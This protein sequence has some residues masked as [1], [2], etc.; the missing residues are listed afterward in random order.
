[1]DLDMLSKMKVDELK[2]FLRLRGLKVSGRKEELVARAF[3]AIE[4]NV[5]IVQTAE[6]VEAVIRKQYLAKLTVALSDKDTEEIPDPFKLS[7]G[8]I[9]EEEGVKLW[10]PTLYPDIFNFLAFHPSELAS[11]DLSDYKTSKGYSYYERG[12]LK[13]LS[14]NEISSASQLCLLKTT[15]RP[16]QRISDVPHKL[17]VC[18]VKKTGKIMSA[19]CSCMAG[20]GQ[21]CNHVAAALF[22]IEAAVRMGLSNPSCTSTTCEWLPN[23]TQV[24]PMKIKDLKLAHGNF[25]RRGKK[26]KELNS[27]PKKM[28]NPTMNFD[29]SLTLTDIC[30]ALKSVCKADESI[31]FAA[32]FKDKPLCEAEAGSNVSI[33]TFEKVLLEASIPEEFFSKMDYFAQHVNEIEEATRGQSDNSFWFMLRKHVITASKVHDVK[34]RMSTYQ[35]KGADTDL[36]SVFDKVAGEKPINPEIAALKYGRAME[37]EAVQAFCTMYARQHSNAKIVDCG[38]FLCRDM[39]FVGGSPDRI[40]VCDCCGRSCLEVKCPYSIAHTT[41]TDQ[42]INLSYLKRGAHSSLMLNRSHRYYTQC[43]VQM[44]ATGITKGYFFVWTSHGTFVEKVSFDE[45]FWDETKKLCN[46]FYWTKYIPF[47]FSKKDA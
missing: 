13:P 41:P 25:G 21:T 14:F 17:W 10:P 20:I 46:D 27:S 38:I 28:Y 26:P 4:N 2:N 34:T 19:H 45:G 30:T 44:A 11:N 43:Q 31:I 47:L 7:E 22:R 40:I 6:E 32:E 37:E 39:P 15:C 36:T 23:N 24:K 42:N 5:Q 33:L 8:W 35:R 16:S 29:K 1:M 3:V 9:S 18:I 12:W